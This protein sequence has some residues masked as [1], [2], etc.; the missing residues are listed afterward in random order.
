MLRTLLK[1]PAVVVHRW[2]LV[3]LCTMHMWKELILTDALTY[4]KK[5]YKFK[6]YIVLPLFKNCVEKLPLCYEFFVLW[7]RKKKIWSFKVRWAFFGPNNS[8]S[9]PIINKSVNNKSTVRDLKIEHYAIYKWWT[10]NQI[11]DKCC[12]LICQKNE[13]LQTFLI[14]KPAS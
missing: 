3:Y 1:G 6:L 2:L 7:S 11:S 4:P 8:L 12:N 14:K 10:S 9:D 13:T 5:F